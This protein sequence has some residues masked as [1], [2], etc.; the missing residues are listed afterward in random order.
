MEKRIFS[1]KDTAKYIKFRIDNFLKLNFK[2]ISRSKLQK[3][4]N[5]GYVKINNKT[6][7]ETSKKIK[8]NDEIEINFPPPKETHIKPYKMPLNILYEDNDIIVIN[9]LP[10]DVIHPGA[11]NFEKTIVNGLL[12][13]CKNN[14]SGIGGKL[15]PGIVHRIDKFLQE[16]IKEL[17]RTRI[18]SL[19]HEGEV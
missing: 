5:E 7:V 14:L 3:L 8:I 11:G 19:I 17:S 13:H 10:G 6:I 1:S 15:R 12:F 16:K 4:I 9:K 2:E 18:Q